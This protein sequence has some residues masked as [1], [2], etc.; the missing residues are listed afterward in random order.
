MLNQGRLAKKRGKMSIR[1]LIAGFAVCSASAA[2][3]AQLANGGALPSK[4]EIQGLK[5]LCGGGD[6]QVVQVSGNLDAA[7]SSWKKASAGA[8]VSVAK[9]NLA[10]VIAQVKNDSN[11]AAVTRVYVDCVSDNLQKFLDREAR[12]PRPVSR[13]GQ[14]TLLRSAYASDQEMRSAGCREAEEEARERLQSDC[15]SW[16]VATIRSSCSGT[17]GSPRT[18]TVQVDAEC[19]FR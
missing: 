4:E 16:V 11:L 5:D 17:S 3:F 8:E 10:G 18:Y 7:I 1:S 13:S 12:R 2:T 14:S 6:V 9:K 15:G 19:R